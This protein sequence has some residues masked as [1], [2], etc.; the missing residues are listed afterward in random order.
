MKIFI[1]GA[2]GFIGSRVAQVLLKRGHTLTCL[3][4]DPSRAGAALQG[5]TLA[6]GDVT[7]R[8]SIREPMR[9][10]DAVIHLAGWYML[11]HV[12]KARMRA[13]NVDGARNTLELAAEIGV[14]KIIHVSTVGVFGNTG[15]RLVD[16]T[17]RVTQNELAS[18]YEKTKWAAHYEIAEP[19]QK[20]GAPVI[21]VQPGGAIGSGDTSPIAGFYDFYFRRTPVMFGA[22]SGITWAHVDDVAE[23]IALVLERGQTGEAYVIAGP[24]LTYRDAMRIWEKTTGIPAPK[25]WLPGWFAG[26]MARMMGTVESNVHRDFVLSSE[27]LRALADYTFYASADKAKREL[28]WTPR[29]IEETF[30][31]V[32]EYEMGRRK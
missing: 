8:E 4:R 10:V 9:G 13:I 14:K 3:L 29:P 27:G 19:L 12:D 23:G 28:A 31:D 21:I 24:A 1:T 7:D 11:G 25:I 5:T 2:N 18:E 16:E 26:A 20:R 15:G 6:R 17:Y 22:K 30:R 32:M